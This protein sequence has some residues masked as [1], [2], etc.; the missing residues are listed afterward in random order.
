VAESKV[1]WTEY[2]ALQEQFRQ[3]QKR[4]KGLFSRLFSW[5]FG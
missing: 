4:K 2:Q 5:L 1:D 3:L